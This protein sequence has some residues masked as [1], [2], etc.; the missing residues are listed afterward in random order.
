MAI[1]LGRGARVSDLPA[2][3]PRLALLARGRGARARLTE[4]RS[5]ARSSSPT[6]SRTR[7][8]SAP[9]TRRSWRSRR[10]HAAPS[11][12]SS[13]LVGLAIVRPCPVRA[14]RPGADRC[15]AIVER[16]SARRSRQSFGLASL[17]FA[18]LG[19][20]GVASGP[21]R[22]LGAYDVGVSA[23]TPR[24]GRSPHQIGD[25]CA[26]RP[27][28]RRHRARSRRTRGSRAR[29]PRPCVES[30]ERLRCDHRPPRARRDRAGGLHRRDDL[31][32]TSAS[33]TSS[34]SSRCSPLRSACTRV[35]AAP[36]P[37]S[38]D[39]RRCSRFS[40]CDSRY[41]TTRRTART[42]RCSGRSAAS[43]RGS[44][45]PRAR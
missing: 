18:V 34:S 16:G 40:R 17:V 24:S 13:A 15:G 2:R 11:S 31:R 19:V 37:G 21:Q 41:R 14:A 36:A 12:R 20:V 10:R 9:C 1:S 42:R 27:V 33:A 22:V 23:C 6:R 29:A 28:R 39:S 5:S 45:R 4:S 25:P 30:R 35:E 3:R 7:S 26:A 38:A 32:A 43:R 44:V 8:C